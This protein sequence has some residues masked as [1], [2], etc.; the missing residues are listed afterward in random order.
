M[1]TAF[2][3]ASQGLQEEYRVADLLGLTLQEYRQLSHSGIRQ[4]SGFDGAPLSY[5]ITISPLNPDTILAKLNPKM[6][7]M[8]MIHFPADAFA[9]RDLPMDE[10]G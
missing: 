3:R 5:Y 6:N 10:V 2:K 7:K 4:I 1:N 8:R 9:E